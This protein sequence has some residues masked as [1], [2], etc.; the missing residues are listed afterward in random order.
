MDQA[1]R[2]RREESLLTSLEEFTREHLPAPPA[3]VLEVGCGQG[4]L[5]TALAVAGYDVLGIDPAAPLGDLFRRLTLEELDEPGPYDGVIAALS[6]HHI[7]DL[8]SALDKIVSL[9]TPDGVLVVEEFAWDRLDGATLEWL[10]GQRR[11]LAAAGR[12]EDPGTV[13]ELEREWKAEHLG[14]HGEDPLRLGLAAHFEERAFARTPYLHRM[15]GGGQTEVLEQA[16]VEAGAIQ[17]V[18]FRYAGTPRPRSVAGSASARPG[19]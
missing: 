9:L 14:L 11:A 3:R 13:E 18:G 8:D 15:L 17:A 4:E 6:L 19:I 5:T 1:G 10:H 2:R 12:G 16:L 7:R